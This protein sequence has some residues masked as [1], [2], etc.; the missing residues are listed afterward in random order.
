MNKINFEQSAAAA[1]RMIDG[2]ENFNE[3]VLADAILDEKK[4]QSRKKS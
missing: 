2:R 4:F 1:R 3:N